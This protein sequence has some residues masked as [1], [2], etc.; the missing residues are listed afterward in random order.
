M[1]IAVWGVGQ[2][3]IITKDLIEH[4]YNNV[5]ARIGGEKINVIA[6]VDREDKCA[7]TPTDAVTLSITQFTKLYKRGKMAGI[8]I[9]I[10]GRFDYMTL[11]FDLLAVG[12]RIEDIYYAERLEL[13]QGPR[14]EW[15]PDFLQNYLDKPFLPYLEFHVADQCNLNCRA[16]EHYSGLVKGE[17]FP[18]YKKFEA[19]IQ[20]LKEYIADIGIIR[21]LGGEPLLNPELEKYIGLARTLYP[22]ASIY[23]VTNGLALQV[24]KDS[25]F[26]TLREN[27]VDIQISWYPPLKNRR[28][29]IEQF[30]QEKR[31]QYGFTSLITKFTKKQTMTAGDKNHFYKCYQ[32]HCNN[33]YDGK[34]AAC[35]LPFTTKYFNE[36]FRKDIP[37]DGA[38]DLYEEGM[39][40]QL[41][42]GR[43]LLPF[44]RCAYCTNPVEIPWGMIGKKSELD[45]WIIAER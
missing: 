44:E 14:E 16:C 42:K 17:V 30:L 10:E 26:D 29:Q 38:I 36:Y 39:C 19:D 11:V 35:F 18:D 21:I 3:S 15:L 41:L 34:I 7:E 24:Q 20:K 2:R 40:T 25:L 8:V 4:P 31:V 43:L 5:V 37:Q 1:D 23:L 6:F 45:D 27:D 13:C 9:P 28:E 22:M 12:I 33:L 32:A